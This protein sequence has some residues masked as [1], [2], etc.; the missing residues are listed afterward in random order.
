MKRQNIKFFAL[1]NLKIFSYN[2]QMNFFIHSI[3]IFFVVI[4]LNCKPS[5]RL[6]KP[7]VKMSDTAIALSALFD[8]RFLEQNMPGFGAPGI[9]QQSIFG[10]T[11]L[12]ET[13][14]SL[15]KHI[16]E[17]LGK[18]ILKRISRDSICILS[19]KHNFDSLRFPNFLRIIYFKKID[20]S[21][22]VML[23]ATCVMPGIDRYNQKFNLNLPCIFGM[24]CGGGIDVVI[25]KSK[26]SVRMERIGGWSD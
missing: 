13:N 25:H 14:E 20:S 6:D 8:E 19:K 12:L 5:V 1:T 18:H 24:M 7:K 17:I 21:F 23:E 9:G 26:D 15:N 11:I 4:F 10:D 16:P 3:A 2:N 22:Q